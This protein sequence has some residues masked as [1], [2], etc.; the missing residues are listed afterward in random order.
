M[1]EERLSYYVPV[2]TRTRRVGTGGHS[3]GGWCWQVLASRCNCIRVQPSLKATWRPKACFGF[4]ERN[5][6]SGH[7]V[8]GWFEAL[9]SKGKTTVPSPR[10]SD[11]LDLPSVPRKWTSRM[12]H[13][14]HAVDNPLTA[15]RRRDCYV[16]RTPHLEKCQEAAAMCTLGKRVPESRIQLVGGVILSR[17][18]GQAEPYP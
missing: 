6:R 18:K 15:N 9:S 8:R 2:G 13:A 3:T 17:S 4:V 10:F 16:E 11:I 5:Q 14:M 1:I 7:A 12:L